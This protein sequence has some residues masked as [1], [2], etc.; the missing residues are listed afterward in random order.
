MYIPVG[1][2]CS[3]TIVAAASEGASMGPLHYG[4]CLLYRGNSTLQAEEQT[5]LDGRFKIH[6][7]S[8]ITLFRLANICRRFEGSLYL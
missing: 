6:V 8:S 5:K 2:F 4:N 1:H 7:V 3:T